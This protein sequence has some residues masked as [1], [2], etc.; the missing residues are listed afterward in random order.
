M[1]K[2]RQQEDNE[3]V[4]NDNGFLV[5]LFVMY[6]LGD[7]RAAATQRDIDVIPKPCSKRYMPTP[8]EFRYVPAEIRYVEIAHQSDTEQL[9][10]AY[11]YIRVAR[12]V[13]VNLYGEQHGCEKK[14][15]ARVGRIVCKHGIH[16]RSTVVRHNNLLEQS[17]KDLAHTVHRLRIVEVPPLQKLRQEVRGALYR[18]RHQLRKERQECG[19]GNEVMRGLYLSPID[20]Y[21]I[22]QGLEGVETDTHREN[23]VQEQAIG[24]AAKEFGK[25]TDKEIVILVCAEDSKV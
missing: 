7:D 14:C 9:S 23:Q 2:S 21:G 8:P 1:P 12:E 11:G 6:A 10:R 22:R 25:G 24:L 3:R 20:I 15:T 16:I 17:P 5:R 19:K 18:S 13:A 4:A